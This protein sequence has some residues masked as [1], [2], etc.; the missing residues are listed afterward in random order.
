MNYL[1]RVRTNESKSTHLHQS[2]E[3]FSFSHKTILVSVCV[4][5]DTVNVMYDP[6]P[7]CWH[8]YTK[9]QTVLDKLSFYSLDHYWTWEEV[10]L[11]W[12]SCNLHETPK[13]ARDG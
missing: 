2:I 8:P 1:S 3:A 11:S 13:W 5:T 12:K 10:L 7:I 6:Y 9:F 4:D